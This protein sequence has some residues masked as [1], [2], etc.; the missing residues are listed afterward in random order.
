VIL[1][2]R[3]CIATSL[4]KHAYC[5]LYSKHNFTLRYAVFVLVCGS[6]GVTVALSVLECVFLPSFQPIATQ[7]HVYKVK[8]SL[9]TS[10][11]TGKPSN[12][13]SILGGGRDYSFL[14]S[15]KTG[16]ETNLKV[17]VK[18]QFTLEQVTKAQSVSRCIAVL[19]LQPRR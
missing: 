3:L 8:V 15:L 12:R 1:N 5:L 17:K 7:F 13:D 11:W 18:V 9:V 10:L 19:F 6:K 14:Q 16:S 4:P 2:K